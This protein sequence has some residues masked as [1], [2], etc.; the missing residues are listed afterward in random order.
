M[1]LTGLLI[2]SP[3]FG[4]NQPRLGEPVWF[5]VLL[6]SGVAISSSFDTGVASVARMDSGITMA[7]QIEGEEYKP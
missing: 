5:N 3:P 2:L 6:C 1:K 7:A 4:G